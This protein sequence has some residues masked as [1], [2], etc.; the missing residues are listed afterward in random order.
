MLAITA[1]DGIN[2]F[3]YL[4]DIKKTD[5]QAQQGI[6]SASGKTE[7]FKS[8][9]PLTVTDD[10]WVG[11][12]AV[13][14]RKGQPLDTKLEGD[15]G[16]ALV[17]S[18][19][20]TLNEIAAQVATTTGIPVRVGDIA[21]NQGA[22]GGTA[23]RAPG[24]A[25]NG[26]QPMTISYEGS[27]S[28]FM[29]QVG[30]HFDVS[31]RFD[32]QAIQI[33]KYETRTFV[34][35]ALPGS[36]ALS[37]GFD[38]G[39]DSGGGGGSSGGGSSG[40]GGGSSSSSNEL[41]QSNTS[42]A[43]LDYWKE[44]DASIKSVLAGDGTNIISPTA[45]TITVTATPQLMQRV[46]SFIEAENTRL[47]KQIAI[48]VGI[49]DVQVTDTVDYG[50]NFKS[51]FGTN[52]DTKTAAGTN[53]AFSGATGPAI[54]NSGS[55][56]FSIFKSSEDSNRVIVNALSVLGNVATITRSPIVTLN[57]RPASR[58]LSIDQAYLAS[59]STTLTANVGQTTSLSPAT[60][61]TG[62]TL[63]V[64]PRLLDDGRILIQYSIKISDQVG[65]IASFTSGGNSVQLP[66][67]QNRVFIQ[68]AILE[69]GATLVLSGFEKD[70]KKATTAG[71]GSALAWIVGGYKND[72]HTNSKIVISLT[73]HEIT[74]TRGTT[75]N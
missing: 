30:G 68:Q 45:G 72:D 52:A 75:Y 17:S 51:S 58:K 18:G 73:P 20:M 64:L 29:D 71:I 12:R 57:N 46:A 27:L 48:D 70:L 4:D 28:A 67:V 8:H 25:A 36:T 35:E 49:Y 69:S 63:Q 14:M 7:N 66:T 22:T 6:E 62:V 32:G 40:G 13:R 44:L 19:P 37:D 3:R 65:D 2:D 33:F 60:V 39:S 23:V 53:T 21:L 34:M 9:D 54:P 31:W 5:A 10:I 42:T 50:V 61:S 43:T 41:K 11:N 74:P 1:C 59:S 47:G 26:P 24:A 15:K 16:F 56:T 55:L 38:G